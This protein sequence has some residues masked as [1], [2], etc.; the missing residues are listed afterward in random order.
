VRTH[1]S[2]RTPSMALLAGHAN[3]Q[4]P[5]LHRTFS[6]RSSPSS[7]LVCPRPLPSSQAP[8]LPPATCPYCPHASS[9]QHAWPSPQQAR[10]LRTSVLRLPQTLHV[11]PPQG[12]GFHAAS[13]DRN[14]ATVESGG[15]PHAHTCYLRRHTACTSRLAHSS[16]LLAASLSRGGCGSSS[17]RAFS[18]NRLPHKGKCATSDDLIWKAAAL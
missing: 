11:A 10:H 16:P 8:P 12:G 2:Q 13:R 1:R 3:R 6:V 5:T 4:Q 18:C 14:G 15:T 7:L 9:M 17:S